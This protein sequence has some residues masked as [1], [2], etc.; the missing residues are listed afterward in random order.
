MTTPSRI[1][2]TICGDGGCG[3]SSITL[4][5]VRSAWTSEY[6]PTIE[7][8]YSVTRTIAGV[9]YLLSLTD[10]AG[11]EEYRGLISS[12]S[13]SS[14]AFLLVYDITNPASLHEQLPYFLDMVQ[15]E[16]ETRAEGISRGAGGSG[17][18]AGSKGLPT[19]GGEWATV[20]PVV[21]VAAN[22]C[23]L[24]EQRRVSAR[25]G[26]EWAR[27]RGCGFMETSAR[28]CVNVEETFARKC[29]HL[30]LHTRAVL[31][32]CPLCPIHLIHPAQLA[33]LEWITRAGRGLW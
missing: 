11:Q 18:G 1:S 6:D 23:D 2:I 24:K 7:D 32:V 16:R 8:S 5:L 13:M 27:A 10:T 14:D 21:I 30:P 25:D 9:D 19:S 22:K 26:L 29:M 12:S 3:K 33:V 15:Q 17:S 4:R 28:E 31:S 20:E